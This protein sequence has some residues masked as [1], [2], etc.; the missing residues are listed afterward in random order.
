[1]GKICDANELRT[2]PS[3]VQ[4]PAFPVDIGE[5]HEGER[6]RKPQ[7]YLEFGG[8]KAEAKFELVRPRQLNEIED[9]RIIIEGPD[10]SE[11]A[12][13]G[14]YSLGILIEVAGAKVENDI[15]GVL[16][17]R[18]HYFLNYRLK[19]F[20]VIFGHILILQKKILI[21]HATHW[22]CGLRRLF[23]GDIGNQGLGG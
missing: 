18:I 13:D 11:M 2:L 22:R 12:E 14:S 7:M 8:L 20:L 16:E 15:A 3:G 4:K 5:M 6:V 9:A 21:V 1:M 10:I 19:V 23:L 17:R